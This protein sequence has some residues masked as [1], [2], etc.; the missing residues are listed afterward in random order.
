MNSAPAFH[1]RC[2][3]WLLAGIGAVAAAFPLDDAVDG[4]LVLAGGSA[5]KNL[6]WWCSKIGEG[7]VPAVAGIFFAAVFL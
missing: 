5:W 7:W 2:Q 1:R 4:A 3:F 6:A